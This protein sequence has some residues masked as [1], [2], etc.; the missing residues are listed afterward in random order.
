MEMLSHVYANFPTFWDRHDFCELLVEKDIMPE[1]LKEEC[2]YDYN[3][4]TRELFLKNQKPKK[5]LFS[6]LGMPPKMPENK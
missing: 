1:E 5:K 2:L 4:H 6:M 3:K